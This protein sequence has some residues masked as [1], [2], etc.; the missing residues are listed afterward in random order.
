M[1]QREMLPQPLSLL[2]DLGLIQSSGG[3]IS[4]SVAGDHG[5]LLRKLVYYRRS[6]MNILANKL[7]KYQRIDN[8]WNIYC[9]SISS[10]KTLE[11]QLIS[12]LLCDTCT[13]D[14]P[15]A[16]ICPVVDDLGDTMAEALG[17]NGSNS[18]NPACV[19][20]AIDSICSL[21][22]LIQS[23]MI[24][25]LPLSCLHSGRV[26]R[27]VRYDPN[28]FKS[29]V[30]ESINKI[31]NDH[32]EIL[33]GERTGDGQLIFYPPKPSVHTSRIIAITFGNDK[34][35]DL[36]PMNCYMLS[37][38]TPDNYDPNTS[39]ITFSAKFDEFSPV[40]KEYYDRW[41][42]QSI[43]QTVGGRLR[44]IVT[45]LQVSQLLNSRYITN[46][47]FETLL[48]SASTASQ[49]S[50]MLG[51]NL[52]Q[53]IS[54]KIDLVSP[55][56]VVKIRSQFANKWDDF[57]DSLNQMALRCKDNPS[58]A[59]DVIESEIK[60]RIRQFESAAQKV[61]TGAVSGLGMA[62]L[63]LGFTALAGVAIPALPALGLV[64][65]GGLIGAY[66]SAVEFRSLS[67]G[68]DIIWSRI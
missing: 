60:P 52:L 19:K 3:C 6:T 30:P 39:E 57:R 45:E 8:Q 42:V 61:R 25:M 51:L 18:V 9:N 20:E 36:S 41:V 40:S 11:S 59:I 38:V 58:K 32:V 1:S 63:S 62:T 26:S 22:P 21:S 53:S 35:D 5:E 17:V 44:S 66:P 50:D 12:S 27:A 31:V 14:D 2:E 7:N 64:G 55:E 28:L 16:R 48:A 10:S 29:E 54:C 23:G 49:A 24:Q 68:T 33:H 46:S 67:K 13:V 43:N 65:V 4:T 56:H 47:K 34:V 37:E 15:L